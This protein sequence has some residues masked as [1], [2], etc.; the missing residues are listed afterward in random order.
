MINWNF[1]RKSKKGV[2]YFQIPSFNDTGIVKHGFSSRIGGVSEGE[3]RSLNLGIKTKDDLKNI[4]KNYKKFTEVININY[5]NIVL[6]DQVHKDNILIIDENYKSQDVLLNSKIKEVDSLITNKKN[7][8]LVTVYADCV[9]IF[10]LDKVNKVIA[11]AHAGWRGTALKIGKKTIEKMIQIYRTD[12]KDC[13]VG[14][15]PSI[16]KCCYEVDEMVINEF[17]KHYE[18]V[19]EFAIHK[20]DNKYMLDLWQA[21]KISLLEAGLIS[22]NITISNICTMCNKDLF[23]SHRGENG[24]TG[25]MAAIIE[26]N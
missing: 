16:G 4:E 12:P 19:N 23:F 21:N 3:F 26:L 2:I 5:E 22:T 24:K 17:K 7:I 15:G 25:R 14:I 20:K 13:L 6:S 1:K 11:L 8:A 10:I 9:P 18:D